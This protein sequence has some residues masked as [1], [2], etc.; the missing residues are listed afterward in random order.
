MDKWSKQLRLLHGTHYPVLLIAAIYKC[1]S[2]FSTDPIPFI[3]DEGVNSHYLVSVAEEGTSLQAIVTLRGKFAAEVLKVSYDNGQTL[4]IHSQTVALL[5]R[6]M[7]T[8]DFIRLEGVKAMHIGLRSRTTLHG[9]PDMCHEYRH[10]T[11]NTYI[12]K[13]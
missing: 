8:N 1:S 4:D 13:V 2:I 11:I 6:Q 7:P 5:T 9:T 12:L 3:L 10:I